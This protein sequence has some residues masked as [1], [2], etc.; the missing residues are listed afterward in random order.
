MKILSFQIAYEWEPYKVDCKHLAFRD[1]EENNIE[2]TKNRISHCGPA[3]YKWEGRIDI[4]EHEGKIGIYI[5]ETKDISPR[6]NQY[7]NGEQK[8]NECLREEFL[9]KGTIYFWI[10]NLKKFICNG[11][12][13]P[14]QI[15]CKNFRL[16]IENSLMIEI[17]LSSDQESTWFVNRIQ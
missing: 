1:Y 6:L 2:L 12:E 3:I 7:K 9:N 14:I 15:K 11:K 5:G 10:L 4:G 8:G 13:Q 16:L 17:L